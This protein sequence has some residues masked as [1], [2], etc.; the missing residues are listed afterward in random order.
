[1]VTD[2]AAILDG[3]HGTSGLDVV[4]VTVGMSTIADVDFGYNR[5][6]SNGVIGNRIWFD[7]NRDG[8]QNGSEGGLR[9]VTVELWEDADGDGVRSAGDT[10]VTTTTTGVDGSYLFAD[11]PPGTYFADPTEG[12]LPTGFAATTGT[13]PSSPAIA[14]SPGEAYLDANFGYA[15]TT[16]IAIGDTVFFDDNGNGSQEPGEIGLG[17]VDVTVTGPGGYSQTVT[18]DADGSWLVTGR[19]D[20]R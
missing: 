4:E 1:M 3:F 8:D 20:L 14:L 5:D 2:D 19:D 18:T 12:T 10:L 16:G 15:P 7:A 11:L 9:G 17:G 13:G 6:A